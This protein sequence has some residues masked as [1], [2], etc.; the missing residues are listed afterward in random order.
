MLVD[1][2]AAND[3][4]LHHGLFCK[5]LKL[6]PDKRMVCMIIE[7]YEYA[8]TTN[9]DLGSPL[10][11]IY[12]RGNINLILPLCGHFPF[13]RQVCAIFL[14]KKVEKEAKEGK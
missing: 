7:L 1:L 13:S 2:R 3:T 11:S 14:V 10:I 9:I 4:V 12:I 5:L 6:Q 8:H